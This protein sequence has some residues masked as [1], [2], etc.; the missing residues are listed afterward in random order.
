MARNMG[1]DFGLQSSKNN[2]M[3]ACKRKFRY[4]F[5]INGISAQGANALPPS[6]AARPSLGFKEMEI[7]HVTETIYYP[8]KPD[9]KPINLVLYDLKRATHPVFQWLQGVYDPAS[10]QANWFP[11]STNN[12]IKQATLELYDSC[13]NTVERWIYENC[14]PSNVEFGSLE[15]GSSEVVMCEFTLRYARAYIDPSLRL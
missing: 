5:M 4:L 12:F 2:P 10:T 1:L 13:G 3:T 6:Q 9:W 8:Q 15:M 14:W 7:Q 11:V